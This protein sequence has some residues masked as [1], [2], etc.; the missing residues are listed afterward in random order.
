MD[1][2][3]VSFLDLL[4]GLVGVALLEDPSDGLDHVIAALVAGYGHRG[5]L[6]GREIA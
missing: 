4:L 5:T 3:S 1:G 6:E 2:S